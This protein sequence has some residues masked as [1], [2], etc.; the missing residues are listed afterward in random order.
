MAQFLMEP[1][2]GAISRIGE[3]RDRARP[4][5]RA[6]VLP[7]AGHVDGA[8]SGDG[9]RPLA[10]AQALA[11]DLKPHT[12]TGVYLNYTSDEGDER[13]RSTYGPE[14]Y[15]R[16]VAL[17]DRYDPENL[18]RLNANIRPSASGR[19]SGPRARRPAP[20]GVVAGIEPAGDD[21]DLP[22]QAEVAA[23]LRIAR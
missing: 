16:L 10:W 13:V 6:L 12:T 9:G 23:A 15:A 17:K 14:K 22:G 4:A 19:G 7:R 1:M 18:F 11:D 3:R 8:R 5:R 21:F 20:H 2:G